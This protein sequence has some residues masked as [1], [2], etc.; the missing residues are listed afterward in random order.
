MV[1]LLYLPNGVDPTSLEH[2]VRAKLRKNQVS[3]I[4]VDV[5]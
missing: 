5:V 3:K 1:F 4:A 2:E